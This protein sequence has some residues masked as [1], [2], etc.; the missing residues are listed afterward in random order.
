MRDRAALSWNMAFPILVMIGFASIFSGGEQEY[1]KVGVMGAGEHP[2]LQSRYIHF[3]P[4]EG[5]QGLA[6]A[7]TKVE[8]HQIDLLLQL[9]PTHRYW[10]NSDS[11]KGYAVEQILRASGGDEVVRQEVS[12]EE[13]RYIDWVIPGVLGMNMMFSALFGIGFVIVRY[14]KNGVLKRFKGTPVTTLEFISAQIISRLLMIVSMALLVYLTCD[15]LLDFAMYGS[16]LALFVVLVLGGFSLI[17]LG[18]IIAAR[19]TSDEVASGLVNL[20]GM[21]MMILSGVWFSLEGSPQWVLYVAQIF[22]LTH[23]VDAARAVMLDGAGIIAIAP[24]LLIL[25]GMSALFLL[26]GVW[27]FRWE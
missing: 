19:I 15:L 23:I 3:I 14:R 13:I 27:L 2:F 10:I 20:L 9:E 8:R 16:Y 25:G 26:L 4:V 5:Q 1:F 24:Q 12:G 21:P 6:E 11:A 7:I 17:C 18:L 22:P